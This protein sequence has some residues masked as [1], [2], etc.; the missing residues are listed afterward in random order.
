PVRLVNVDSDIY[1]SARFV[2][3]ALAE[4][5]RPGTILVFDEFIGNRSW[6]DD[7]FRAFHEFIAATGF[8][9]E[10]LAASPAT[11][12]VVV[13]LK[14]VADRAAFRPCPVRY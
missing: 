9:F 13:R 6:A 10:Y 4:R 2:L 7:E 3:F 11:K 12:Q 8:G 1:S 14:A 5:M